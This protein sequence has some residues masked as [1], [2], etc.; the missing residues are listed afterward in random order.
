MKTLIIYNTASGATKEYADWIGDALKANVVAEKDVDSSMIS[1]YQTLIFGSCVQGGK[2]KIASWVTSH[3]KQVKDKK[4]IVY[5]V[6]GADPT[7]TS[8]MRKYFDE[9]FSKEMQKHMTMFSLHGRISFKNFPMIVRLI[10]KFVR[11]VSKNPDVQKF[12]TEF[13]DVKKE[14]IAPIISAAKK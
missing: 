5:S 1:T 12:T 6:S 7:E 9:S 10:V 4:I 3:W 11:K 14:Y 2:L 13:D 8:V